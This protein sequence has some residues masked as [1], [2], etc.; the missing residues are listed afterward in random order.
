MDVVMATGK[1]A[2]MVP[3]HVLVPRE[4]REELDRLAREDRRTLAVT[5]R[6][7]I[8]RLLEERAGTKRAA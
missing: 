7:A 2:E 6:M 1:N 5:V 4:M 3:L 8:E